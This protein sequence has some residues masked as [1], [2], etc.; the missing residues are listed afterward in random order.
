MKKIALF[1]DK[2]V[3]NIPGPDN[4]KVT[5]NF[6]NYEYTFTRNGRK[7]ASVSKKFFS[8]SDTYGIAI[9]PGEDDI[10]ILAAA[11][12]I[13]MASHGDQQQQSTFVY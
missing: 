10:L 3:V 1:N 5:G 13:D 4:Y 11:V 2:Y 12:V 6:G 8:W 7:V 9:A